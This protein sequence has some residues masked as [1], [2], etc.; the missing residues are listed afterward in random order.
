MTDSFVDYAVQIAPPRLTQNEIGRRIVM[1]LLGLPAATAAIMKREAVMCQQQDQLLTPRN[2]EQRSLE[3]RGF[4]QYLNEDRTAMKARVQNSWDDWQSMGFET[5]IEKQLEYCGFPNSKVL[6]TGLLGTVAYP[7]IGEG[8]PGNGPYARDDEDWQTYPAQSAYWSQFIV[9]VPVVDLT[10]YRQ[11]LVATNYDLPYVK[12]DAG[13]YYDST[14]SH[15][16]SQAVLTEIKKIVGTY[17]PV[18]WIGREIVLLPP[19]L[20]AMWNNGD[21]I[22]D[23]Q[24]VLGYQDCERW[25]PIY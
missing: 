18:D 2:S 21:F 10:R 3:D 16:V 4:F 25:N 6:S 20:A 8:Q 15:C 14:Q 19:A 23:P 9:I 24:T 5:G 12:W 7:F 13:F 22:N 11:W 1:T 17:K